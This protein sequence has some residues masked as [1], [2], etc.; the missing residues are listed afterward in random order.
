MTRSRFGTELWALANERRK[1]AGRESRG[2]EGSREKL[3]EKEAGK[4]ALSCC[5]ASANVVQVMLAVY[6]CI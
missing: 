5:C 4:E 6:Y 1:G 3:A 2:R